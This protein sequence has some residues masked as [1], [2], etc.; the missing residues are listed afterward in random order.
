MVNALD[1]QRFGRLTVLQRHPVNSNAGKARWMCRCDCGKTTVQVGGSLTSG[2]IL[3]CGCQR[4]DRGRERLS[5]HG[6]SRTSSAYSPWKAM[7][8][9]CTNPNDYSYARYGGAGITVCQRWND[10]TTFLA[11][12]GPRPSPR[13]SIERLDNNGHYEPTNCVWA[14]SLQQ[15]RNTRRNRKYTHLGRTQ[16]LSQWCQEL[17]LKYRRTLMR[18][19]RGWTFSRAVSMP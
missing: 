18:L 15:G 16:P 6:L 10:F 5:T 4:D 7:R 3:S 1:G 13:H 17:G 2:H 8:K 9:R 19:R 14:T 12:M 11:D